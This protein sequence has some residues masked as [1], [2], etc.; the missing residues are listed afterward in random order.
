MTDELRKFLE[1]ETAKDE[2]V[3]ER[4]I[5]CGFSGHVIDAYKNAAID[6]RNFCLNSTQLSIRAKSL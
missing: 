3:E 5:P 4:T 2:E 6:L 1:E